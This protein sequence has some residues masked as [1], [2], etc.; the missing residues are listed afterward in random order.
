MRDIVRAL[1]A[2]GFQCRTSKRLHVIVYREGR[3]V[4]TLA[5]TSGGGRGYRNALAELRRAGFTWP[6]R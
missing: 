2:Q 5:G 6:T 1:E 4:A 3:R